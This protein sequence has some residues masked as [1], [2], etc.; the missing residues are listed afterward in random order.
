MRELPKS[1]VT[2]RV[3]RLPSRFPPRPARGAR[4]GR[5]GPWQR[6]SAGP[7]CPPG[8]AAAGDRKRDPR[9]RAPPR[10]PPGRA[11]RPPRP[12]PCCGCR[13]GCAAACGRGR[14][15]PPAP[16][17][18]RAPP[19]PPA[20][21]FAFAPRRLRL[22]AHHP[23]LEDGDVHRH[24]YLQGVLTSL[25]EVAE[26]PKVSEFS[27]HISGCCQVFDTV[28]GYEHHY[29]TLHRNVCSFCKRS[30]P[31]GHLLDIHI[32]EWH[33]SLFQIMAEKQNMY[34]C[35]V[36]GCAEKFKSSK[37]RKDHLVTVHLYP[38]DFRFDRP[39]KVKSGPKHVSSPTKQGARVPVDVS[40]ETSEQFQV[41]PMETGPSEN[42]EI[43]QPAASPGPLVP[44][45]RLYKSRIPSTIC[46]GQ[47]ATRGFKGPRKKV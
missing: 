18:P 21:P 16:P 28:E 32:L 25:A 40:M 42:M 35:L 45:K 26:R 11:P 30:F 44:E 4:D 37:D 22:G 9:V 7:T 39:K 41:D 3:P 24:L 38:A 10:Q 31:S 47:G 12:A 43:P 2:R 19:A 8:S 27:C 13:P 5:G 34:K 29:N 46:F 36:E 17:P 23:V 20:P 1:R 6:L 15:R 33:D 14:P